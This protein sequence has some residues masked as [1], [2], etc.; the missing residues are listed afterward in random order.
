MVA[1]LLVVLATVLALAPWTLAQEH[2]EEKISSEA[3]MGGE[4][5]RRFHRER[6]L[7]ELP[8]PLVQC[9][10]E[11]VGDGH[12]RGWAA[13]EPSEV[14]FLLNARLCHA[15]RRA[16]PFGRIDRAEVLGNNSHNSHKN[17][18]DSLPKHH[19]YAWT[20][21]ISSCLEEWGTSTEVEVF[22]YAKIKDNFHACTPSLA[23]LGRGGASD[24]ETGRR[25]GNTP[26]PGAP[27]QRR[28][29]Y[30]EVRACTI[31]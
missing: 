13:A 20:S 25:V 7:G 24:P 30:Y 29:L 15:A 21:D 18:S 27:F 26:S 10:L 28:G 9:A 11:H 4:S 16:G 12:L 23:L 1:L 3:A 2:H 8:D 6:D 14:K 5:S 22:A 31:G 19:L 17:N